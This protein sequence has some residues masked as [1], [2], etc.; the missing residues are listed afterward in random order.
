MRRIAEVCKDENMD[1]KGQESD[2]ER[3]TAKRKSN[4]G[5]PHHI[6]EQSRAAL[7]A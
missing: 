5:H 2:D 1:T 3:Y 4:V 7:H 6:A